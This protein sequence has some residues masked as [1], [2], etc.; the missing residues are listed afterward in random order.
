M[1]KY[2]GAIGP[3]FAARVRLNQQKLS[4]NL[5]SHYDFIVCGSGSSGSVVARRLAENPHVSVLLLEAGGDDDVPDVMQANQWPRNLGSQRDWSFQA[6]PN[7]RLNGR[8]VPLSMGR[9]LGGGSSINVMAWSRGHKDDWDFFASEAGDPAWSYESVLSIYRR[10]EDWHGVPDPKY[11]GTGGLIFVQPAPAPHP[12]APA[13][14][15]GCQS[16]GLPVYENQ[17][18]RMMEA[19]GGASI[20]D[21]R[22]RDGKRQ[23]VFRTYVFPYMDRPNLTVLSHALVTRLTFDGNRATG[24]EVVHNGKMHSVTATSEIVVSLGA[25]NTPKLLMQ[26]GIGNETELQRFGIPIVQH[27]PG[28]GQ[29]LQDHVGFDCVW[30][31]HEALSPRNNFAEA[32]YFWKSDSKLNAP[33]LQVCHGEFTKAT[34]ENIARFQPPANGW[35]LFGGLQRP[36]S[37]GQIVLTGPKPSD[38]VQIE[39]NFLSHPDDMRAAIACVELCREVGNS[40]AL[41]RFAKREIMPGNLQGADLENYIRDAA[42]TYWHQTCTAKMGRDPMSVVDGALKV[43]GIDNLRIADGSIMPRVTIGNTMAPCVIIGERAAEIIKTGHKL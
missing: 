1:S 3:E 36:K 16:I 9:V 28:V 7:P 5:K 31:P 35:I 2:S 22:V 30:E 6:M 15:E 40:A 32:T 19:E 27:L 38:P 10:I 11:R 24:V 39:T 20:T 12:I 37:K 26:S 42:S 33:D 18:G 14:L 43:Y 8:S 17:N 4:S 34:P 25:I 41:T 21:I 13:V 23:S 29:N